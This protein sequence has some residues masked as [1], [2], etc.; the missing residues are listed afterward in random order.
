MRKLTRLIRLPF[1]DSKRITKFVNYK[2]GGPEN[3]FL[4]EREL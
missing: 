1:S 4:D 3:M 2:D